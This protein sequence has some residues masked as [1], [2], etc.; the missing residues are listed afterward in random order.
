[1][2][3]DVFEWDDDKAQANLA[4]HGIGFEAAQLVFSDAFSV[5]RLDTVSDPT[6][7]RFVDWHGERHDPDRRLYGAWGTHAH[8]LGTKSNAA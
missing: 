4:K 2:Q 3:G 6:E 8:H 7:L 1:M 5:E